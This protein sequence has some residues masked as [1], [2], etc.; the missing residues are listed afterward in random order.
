MTE[1]E[2]A[3]LIADGVTWNELPEIYLQPEWCQYPKALDGPMGCWSLTTRKIK[4]N[5]FC[6]NYDCYKELH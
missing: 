4:N 3:A 6:K 2:F 5:S 1:E